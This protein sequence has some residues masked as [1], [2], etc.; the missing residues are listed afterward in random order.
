MSLQPLGVSGNFEGD[1]AFLILS[2]LHSC[3]WLSESSLGAVVS[4]STC[5]KMETLKACIII[6]ITST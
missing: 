4:P 3:K 2:Y 5:S 6:T 1:K